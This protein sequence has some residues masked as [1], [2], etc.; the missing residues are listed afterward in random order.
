[1]IASSKRMD[2]N[3]WYFFAIKTKLIN[4]IKMSLNLPSIECLRVD[5][6]EINRNTKNELRLRFIVMAL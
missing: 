4:M 6:S 5:L 3:E 1:M 2:R